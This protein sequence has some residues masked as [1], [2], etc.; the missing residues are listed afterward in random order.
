MPYAKELGLMAVSVLLRYQH[1]DQRSEHLVPM[2]I[3]ALFLKH[4]RKPDKR[5][6]H[7]GVDGNID[8]D[9][10]IDRFD[11]APVCLQNV[12]DARKRC[13]SATS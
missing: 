13:S 6:E 9:G 11:D 5:E 2:R 3:F 10:P 7:T 4:F 12:A 8:Q 1:G